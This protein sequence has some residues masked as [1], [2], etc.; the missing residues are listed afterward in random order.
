MWVTDMAL[1]AILM[2]LGKALLEEEKVK[3]LRS[4]FG[5]ALMISCA[6]GPLIGGIGT[7]AGCGPNPIAI[8]FLKEM[9]GVDLSFLRWMAYGV[10]SALLLIVPAWLILLFIFP[11]EISHLRRH[12]NE[13]KKEFQNLPPMHRDE[14][15][16]VVV[17]ILTVSLWI[18][19]PFLESRLYMEIPISM[20]I[21]L[22]SALLFL[23]GLTG[24]KWK[25]IEKDISW[26]GIILVVS[27]ISLGMMLYNTGAAEWLS[28]LLLRGLADVGL[29]LRILLIILIVSLLKIFLSSNTVTATIIIPIIIALSKSLGLDALGLALP[30]AITSSLAFILVT[31]TPTN[32][33]PYSAGYFSISDLAKAG[34]VMTIVSS[35]IVALVIYLIGRL[36]AG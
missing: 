33:I 8:G 35:P 31:S 5:R 13:L 9:A 23:P 10:P 24:V 3:P 36:A 20:V 29:F 12:K 17:F 19:T 30:A 2:P 26:S 27:G 16:T 14:I 6:W 28:I 4:N 21:L 11:P 25:D 15:V 7:P 1:A 34:I 32:V 22:T 18:L